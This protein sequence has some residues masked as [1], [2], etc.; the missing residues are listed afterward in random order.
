[1]SRAAYVFGADNY[2]NIN[3]DKNAVPIENF[4]NTD[5]NCES[6]SEKVKCDAEDKIQAFQVRAYRQESILR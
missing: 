2:R 3:I 4:M 6:R 1:M 5:K